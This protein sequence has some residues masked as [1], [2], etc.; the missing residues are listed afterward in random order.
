LIWG[1]NIKLSI[2]FVLEHRLFVIAVSGHFV[3]LPAPYLHTRF[4]HQIS[5]FP[6]TNRVTQRIERLSDSAA[7]VAMIAGVRYASNRFKYFLV[8][9]VR[10]TIVS[11]PDILIVG[12][13]YD[14]S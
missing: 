11:A 1:F 8:I 2:Q 7:A 4:S 9:R 12:T 13:C 14:S 6:A 3:L 10:R 5:S